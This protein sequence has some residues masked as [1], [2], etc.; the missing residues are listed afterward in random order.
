LEKIF[1]KKTVNALDRYLIFKE[2]T[3]RFYLNL[4]TGS[5]KNFPA[6]LSPKKFQ[7]SDKIEST[8]VP[9]HSTVGKNK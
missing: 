9:T 1:F 3:G 6:S 4:S 8:E 2:S 7:N 5:P